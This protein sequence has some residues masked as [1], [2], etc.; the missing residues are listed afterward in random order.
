M[1]ERAC[2]RYTVAN[3]NFSVE[4]VS[5]NDSSYTLLVKDSQKSYTIALELDNQQFR[6]VCDMLVAAR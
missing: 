3:S 6:T 4:V 1:T 2:K 5:A